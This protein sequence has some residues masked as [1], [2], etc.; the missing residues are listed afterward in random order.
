MESVKNWISNVLLN[1]VRN[2]DMTSIFFLFTT[3]TPHIHLALLDSMR[4]RG[5]ERGRGRET[6]RERESGRDD[7]Q[8]K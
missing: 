7:R 5:V 1:F 4:W 2:T 8:Q 6:G 3:L